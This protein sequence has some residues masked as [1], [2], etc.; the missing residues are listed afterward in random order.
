METPLTPLEFARRARKLYPERV[1]VIDGDSR[2]T[3]EQFLDLFRSAIRP[4][5]D[6][7]P[8][9]DLWPEVAGP[10][11]TPAR[12]SWV[13]SSVAAVIVAVL[14][15]FPNWVFLLAFHL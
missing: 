8:A 2:W 6:I 3:Y 12:W 13:D 11:R 1:A 4:M 7:R 5:P 10:R 14:V 9:R 15:M